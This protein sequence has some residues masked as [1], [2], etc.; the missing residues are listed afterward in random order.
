MP[1]R[2]E[3][4][5]TVERTTGAVAWRVLTEDRLQDDLA[6]TAAALDF[7]IV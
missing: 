5:E 6:T 1:R 4:L 2:D 3:L 7:K